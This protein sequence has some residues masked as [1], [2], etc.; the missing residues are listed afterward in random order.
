MCGNPGCHRHVGV[1]IKCIS[2]KL[3]S[4]TAEYFTKADWRGK[5]FDRLCSQ[6]LSIAARLVHSPLGTP[7]HTTTAKLHQQRHTGSAKPAD[8]I[9]RP[10]HRSGPA[11]LLGKDARHNRCAD[12]L[13]GRSAN[14]VSKGTLLLFHRMTC[15]RELRSGKIGQMHSSRRSLPVRVPQKGEKSIPK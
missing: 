2:L 6:A 12:S 1:N 5:F 10:E 13:T 11:A 14:V 7:H 15:R 9:R 8:F 4:H 3:C